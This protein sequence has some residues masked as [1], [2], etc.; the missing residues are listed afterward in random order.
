MPHVIHGEQTT[1]FY[2]DTS[3]EYKYPEGLDLRPESELSQELIK[4][5]MERAQ[6]SKTAYS[7]R[8]NAW[9]R[10]D[11]YLRLYHR[12]DIKSGQTEPIDRP[13]EAE[14]YRIHDDMGLP[15]IIMPSSHAALETLLTYTTQ[16]LLQYPIF[17]FNGTGPEDVQGAY[18]LQLLMDQHA[19]K[20]GYILALHTM[21]RDTFAYGLGPIQP[22]WAVER[23]RWTEKT[24]GGHHT[25][26]GFVP[27][28]TQLRQRV[29]GILFEGNDLEAIDPYQFFPDPNVPVEQVDRA[30][31]Q[32]FLTRYNYGFLRGMEIPA[33]ET[34]YNVRYARH[35]SGRSSLRNPDRDNSGGRDGQQLSLN[36]SSPIDILWAYIRIIP[37]EWKLS[38]ST[39]PEI[40]L[41]GIA[42]DKIII[43]AEKTD[44]D[45]GRMR[46]RVAAPTS[47]GHTSAPIAALETVAPL[48]AF[49]DFLYTSHITNVS[50]SLND[51]FV[52]DPGLVNVNDLLD[53]RPGKL[54]RMRP[55]Q[56]GRGKVT[57][58]IH[59]FNVSDVTQGHPG[60]ADR[61]EQK[62]L[63]TV[64]A[65]ENMRGKLTHSGPRIS[66]SQAEGARM[67]SMSHMDRLSLLISLQVI[68]PLGEIMASNIQQYMTEDTYLRL[69][70]TQEERVSELWGEEIQ[71]GRVKV[72]PLDLI[73]RHDVIAGDN[74]MASSQDAD[75][76]LELVEIA[77]RTQHPEIIQRLDFLRLFVQIARQRGMKNPEDFIRMVPPAPTVV[78]DEDVEN[79]VQAGNLIPAV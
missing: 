28:G 78:P 68:T 10:T 59:Q 53:P 62:I 13:K 33:E 6:K 75:T 57:E 38:E 22:R 25:Q 8:R 64:G 30:E 48:Q 5:I 19:R 43:H 76:L 73:I 20:R 29:E 9:R 32:M 54:I 2:S 66:A 67:S 46:V 44:D 26:T 31:F 52:V 37:K 15:N 49:V 74:F 18:L 23:G 72:S 56:W 41:F 36:D 16:A 7:D 47:D 27:D 24:P 39:D 79:Q 3:Y 55:A 77:L 12:P 61:L 14:K 21:L 40:W 69:T 11:K 51:M 42:A 58:A 35:T 4:R 45:H 34:F 65:N 70:G 17:T 50:K 1:A 71:N 63:E 60:M